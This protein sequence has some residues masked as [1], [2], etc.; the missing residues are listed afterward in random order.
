MGKEPTMKYKCTWWNE[1][2]AGDL[3][4]EYETEKDAQA[5]ADKW[6]AEMG[7]GHEAE[8][9]ECEDEEEDEAEEPF[10]PVQMGWVDQY[11]RP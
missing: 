7:K 5:A 3:P 4:G 8:V 9:V 1:H 10:D 2:A 11:G 6:M